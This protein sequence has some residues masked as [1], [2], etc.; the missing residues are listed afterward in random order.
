MNAQ[1]MQALA[2]TASEVRRESGRSHTMP[3][4]KVGKHLWDDSP[5]ASHQTPTRYGRTPYK[6]KQEA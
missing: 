4:G 1:L 2:K 3:V 5:P 6:R